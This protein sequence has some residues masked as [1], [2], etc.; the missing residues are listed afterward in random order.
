METPNIP[1]LPSFVLT[2]SVAEHEGGIINIPTRYSEYFGPHDSLINVE[3]P[4]SLS[5][6][7]KGERNNVPN[8]AVRIS[9]SKLKHYFKDKSQK[10][11]Q[12]KV[13]ITGQNRIRIRPL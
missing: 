11:V 8:H 3:L 6:N 12:Y 9:S 7:C 10:G 13:I 1:V 5:I 4:N 2:T